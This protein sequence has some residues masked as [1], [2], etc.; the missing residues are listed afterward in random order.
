MVKTGDV[1][2]WTGVLTGVGVGTYALFRFLK[3][4]GGVGN[5]NGGGNGDGLEPVTQAECEALGFTWDESKPVGQKC[6][7][8]ED[9]N[10]GPPPITE[11]P[12]FVD[13]DKTAKNSRE[14]KFPLVIETELAGQSR[15]YKA[16]SISG[17]VKFGGQLGFGIKLDVRVKLPSGTWVNIGTVKGNSQDIVP[18]SFSI[19]R[20]ITDIGFK[21]RKGTLGATFFVDRATV[22]LIVMVLG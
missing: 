7:T 6:V 20:L 14:I 22:T 9:G 16:T 8:G 4:T 21:T 3:A 2:L 11:I 19:G 5:G 17:Q 15:P 18:F 13:L 1:I 10:G 12:I